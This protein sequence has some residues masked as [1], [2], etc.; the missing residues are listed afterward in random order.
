MRRD[1]ARGFQFELVALAV[2]EGEC[3]ADEPVAPGQSQA[4]GGIEAAAEQ[5]DGFFGRCVQRRV[6]YNYSDDRPGGLSH[7]K[8]ASSP[9]LR[10]M[11]PAAAARTWGCACWRRL[12]KRWATRWIS[13]RRACCC[14]STRRSGWEIGR[15]ACG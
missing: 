12:S 2:I 15:A 14:R 9:P 11:S 5:A 8:S 13:K 7:C 6:L 1:A 4:G 3:V 10:S